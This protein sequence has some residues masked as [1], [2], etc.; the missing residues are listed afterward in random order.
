MNPSE[1]TVK[2][3]HGSVHYWVYNPDKK[4]TLVMIHGFRG[5]H[6][7]LARIAEHLPDF[8]LIIPDL[9]GFG[10][11]DAFVTKKHSVESYVNFLKDFVQTLNL[12]KPIIVGH[13]FGSIIA[14]HFVATYPNA[15]SRLILINPI[16]APA[17][18]GPRGVMTRLAVLYYWIGRKLP[19]TAAKSWLGAPPIVKIMSV[20]MAKTKDKDIQRYIH[21]QHKKHFS[22]FAS[23]AVVSES[24]K[25]SVSSDVS[26]VAHTLTLPTLLIAGDKDDITS[27]DK[28]HELHASIPTSELRVIKDVGHLIHYETPGEAAQH[29]TE[30]LK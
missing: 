13:S 24:F 5:T 19:Q 7:G 29:I 6:H 10:S 21:D 8:R 20:T 3:A 9:P 11:S 1:K 14:S 23:P 12:N 2:L 17:L 18:E 15:T 27:V 22:T 25:A 26:H 28:Q 16:G 30:F 4:Q